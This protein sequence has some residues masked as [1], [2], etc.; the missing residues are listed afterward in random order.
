MRGYAEE[1]TI[2]TAKCT[3]FNATIVPLYF[4]IFSELFLKQLKH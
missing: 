3:N 2:N 4:F 1:Q